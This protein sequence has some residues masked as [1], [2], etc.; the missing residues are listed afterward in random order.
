MK[1]KRKRITKKGYLTLSLI[2]VILMTFIGSAI[3]NSFDNKTEYI[4]VTVKAGQNLWQ[5]A[6]TYDNNKIDLRK[7]IYDIKKLN[8]IAKDSM[9]YPG[10]ILKIPV[11]N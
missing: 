11:L 10:Q 6:D 3:G 4:E 7:F 9:I 5:I 1:T 8:N 2:V